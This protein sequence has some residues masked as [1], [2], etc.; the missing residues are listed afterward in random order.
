M[1]KEKQKKTRS[2]INTD[3]RESL[4]LF[5]AL[6]VAFLVLCALVI[7]LSNSLLSAEQLKLENELE[8][9]FNTTILD[10]QEGDMSVQNLSSDESLIGIGLYSSLGSLIQ[11][12]GNVPNRLSVLSLRQEAENSP[13]DSV[14]TLY[15]RTGTMEYVRFLKQTIVMPSNTNI[16][17]R[18]GFLSLGLESPSIVYIA[19][20]AS[21]YLMARRMIYLGTGLGII[22]LII[23]FIVV[24]K[25]LND[26]RR[27]KSQMQKQESLVNMGQAARTLAHEI[28]NPLSAITIQIALL[29]KQLRD[30]DHFDELKL[31]EREVQRLIELT[32]KVSDFLRNP[33]GQPSQIDLVELINSLLPLFT[34]DVSITEDSVKTAL[35]YFDINRARSVFENII[36]NAVESRDDGQSA[37]VEIDIKLDKKGNYHVFVKDRGYGISQKNIKK[38]FDPFYTTKIH[39]SGI[40]LSISQ[41]FVK[42]R[43]GLIK[44][45]SRDGGGTIV[46]TILPK[47]SLVQEIVD[48]TVPVFERKLK[49]EKNESFN[50]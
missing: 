14:S 46:E 7:F 41:Q 21:S 30:T 8:R 24:L 33:L 22:S 25:V 11:A 28:K 44:I 50:S 45:H 1:K 2:E 43:G 34:E 40:G 48:K 18:G 20:N 29:K 19:F 49:E 16:I 27:F 39:G 6:S 47:Y 23:V 13:T 38:L 31:V 42:A 4:I 3:R 12:W 36:K 35:V 17:S 10:I 37:D 26:N 32:N 15:S 5:T 9:T